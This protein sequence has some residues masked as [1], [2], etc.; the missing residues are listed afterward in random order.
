MLR[1][2]AA[3]ALLVC[4]VALAARAAEGQA[5]EAKADV[6]R[7]VKVAQRGEYDANALLLQS[8]WE[9]HEIFPFLDLLET[10]KPSRPR[11]DTRHAYQ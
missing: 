11:W 7:E 1:I 3:L 10:Q 8:A 4:N 5:Q 9:Q 6:E 2:L